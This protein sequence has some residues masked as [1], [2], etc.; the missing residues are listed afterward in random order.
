MLESPTNR[1]SSFLKCRD[2]LPMPPLDF[3]TSERLVVKAAFESDR[4]KNVQ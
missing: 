2:Y 1:L 3:E 4:H